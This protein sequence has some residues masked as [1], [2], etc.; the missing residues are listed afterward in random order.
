MYLEKINSPEDL[1]N[2][3]LDD[4]N[5]LS[6]EI[7]EVLLKKLSE[8]GG[9]IGP[10]LGIVEITV[11][12]HHVFN[13]PKDKIV[14]D[15][16]HQSYIHKM[17]TGRK[18]A[19]I[20]SEKYDEVSG[21][22]NPEESKHDFFNIGHTSTSISLACGLAKA[23]D[24][25]EENDNVIAIIG[26][27]SLSGGE[28]YEGLNNA[29]EAGTNLI[30]IVN[31]NDM[32]IAENYGGLYKNLKALRDTEGKAECNFFKAMG[33]DY[34]YVKDGH[35]IEELINVFNK[36]K[37]TDKPVVVHIH[38]I[39]GKGFEFAEKNKEQWHWGMPFV[40]ETGESKFSNGSTKDYGNLTGE[41]LLEAMKEDHKVVAIASGT[42]A[43]IGF[44]SDRRKEA[45]KQFVDVGIAEEHAVAL[46]SGIATNGGKPV[47]GVYSTFLQRTYDQLSQD[48]CINNSP[49]VIAVFAAS[50]Y[51]MND[52]THLGL[53][54]IGMMSNIPN[55]IYLAPTC[56]EEYFSMLKWG[57]NQKDHP[58]AIRVPGLGVVESG[59]EDK[60][61]YSKLNKYQVT[62]EGKDVAVVA[63][64]GFYKLGQTVVTK[65]SEEHGIDA[66]LINPK[67]IT[68]FDEELLENLKKEH[69]LVITLEDGILDG[70]FGEKIARYYG[71]SDMKILNYGIKKELLDR[72]VPAELMKKNRLTDEQIVEDVLSIIK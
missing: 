60:T 58:V 66:T 40:L 56:K 19:F 67:Y 13:S 55:M 1:K 17:L 2:L 54:D 68:G 63:L 45:G 53:Y 33:L 71:S 41:Y 47:Y 22:S 16:S 15:V 70:G 44:N 30:I 62:K 38:T 39:K 4:M 64:G 23:R 59:V 6:S 48:L 69:K 18:E 24:L 35:D 25:K 49:A 20:N 29:A 51:G 57:I 42:P 50:V 36:V 52:V 61:D 12:L 31:D 65:L 3:S 43:V 37:D 8:H 14:Y 72:Y 5:V 34:Q 11:A 27:G 7:R 26:D 28:A 10:N 46:A 9:H 21:Y 32:S